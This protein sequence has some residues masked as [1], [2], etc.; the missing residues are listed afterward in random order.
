[1]DSPTPHDAPPSV[2]VP[3]QASRSNGYEPPRI[4]SLGTV[5]ELTMG[6]PTPSISDV[7]IMFSSVLS[8][9]RLKDHV[10]AFD[11]GSVLEGVA[12]LASRSA[13]GPDQRGSSR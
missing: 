5:D 6:G 1:M 8:D 10:T 12:S 3:P 7:G 4:E 2:P 11:T 9:R 13:L